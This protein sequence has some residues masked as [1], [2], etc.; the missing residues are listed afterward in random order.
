TE[1]GEV[2]LTVG[3]RRLEAGDGA[4]PRYRLEFAVRDTGIGIPEDRRDRLFA[5]FSQVDASTTRRHGGTGLGLAI[6]RRLV[7]LMGGTISV[8][9]RVGEGST[10]RFTIVAD[11]APSPIPAFVGGEKPLLAGRRVLVVD[12][13]ATNREILVRQ[14]GS[15]GMSARAAAS[16]GEALGWIASGEPFDLGILDLQMPEMDGVALAR[17]IREHRPAATLPLV[18]LSSVGRR[19]ERAEQDLFAAELTKPVKPSHLYDTLM[20]LFGGAVSGPAE[21]PAAPAR[22]LADRVPLR[23]L[24][25]EDNTVNQRL[26]LLLLEKLGYRA[27]VVADGQEAVAAVE[28][29]PYDVV[30]MDVQMPEM[31]GLEATRE[32]RQRL[33]EPSR[34]RIVAMTANALQ[35][36]REACL[37]AGMN[38]Y[39]SKPIR[40]DELAA[41]LGRAAGANGAERPAAALDEAALD[42][43][44]RTVGSDEAL[45]SL[46]DTFLADTEQILA[47]LRAAVARDDP[48]ETRRL[49]HSLKSTAASFGATELSTLSRRLEER[50]AGGS[51]DGTAALLAEMEAELPRVREG[52]V[53]V[54]ALRPA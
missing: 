48:T 28:R 6:S 27:D 29:Q 12:D 8:E 31:D 21:A 24:V 43:L 54:G 18:L 53:R 47:G 5:S 38:D 46:V 33:G 37:A 4:G 22:A 13:N 16:A 7:E 2:V 45:A 14:T 1:Q 10:F 49:A 3:S 35:G 52:L 50:A 39:I 23:I 42:Q 32:I 30:L 11:E 15:W 20:E 17:G 40:Q 51:T 41:A 26:I 44:A 25:A 36:D 9:S 19:G 34:P